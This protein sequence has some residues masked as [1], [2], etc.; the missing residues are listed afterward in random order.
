MQA[1]LV[2]ELPAEE[3]ESE[4]PEPEPAP[5][6][7]ADGAM[8]T[9]A[10]RELT[11]TVRPVL[12]RRGEPLSA[13]WSVDKAKYCA[14]ISTGDGISHRFYDL[15]DLSRLYA[16]D[17]EIPFALSLFRWDGGPIEL[18]DTARLGSF[19][20]LEGYETG[21]FGAEG[22]P[23]F[24]LVRFQTEEGGVE[25]FHFFKDARI[26][27][28]RFNQNSASFFLRRDVDSDGIDDLVLFE[29]VYEEGTGK[30][31]FVSWYR[32]GGRS[33]ELYRSTNIVRNLNEFLSGAAG[34]LEAG[35]YSRFL[36]GFVAPGLQ[37]DLREE[38]FSASFAR[39]FRVD[40]NGSGERFDREAF[41]SIQRIAF[42]EI[43][44]NPFDIASGDYGLE[45]PVHFIGEID[46][47][48][49]VSIAMASNPFASRQFYFVTSQ[50]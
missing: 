23:F 32:W 8:L 26:G 50:P 44:E 22:A 42:P 15:N 37:P 2:G 14:V 12:G 19:P 11:G 31:T 4:P 33:L 25:T 20:V 29:A 13:I 30:E 9:A 35:E 46:Y 38:N 45:L 5:E 21:P 40:E 49:R 34:L 17:G 27:S 3:P 43:L 28:S 7:P 1:P 16:E 48:F 36:E 39:I 6:P 18:V 47:R 41:L 10:L 24:L